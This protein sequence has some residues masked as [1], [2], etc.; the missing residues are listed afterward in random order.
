[1]SS[2]GFIMRVLPFAATFAVAIFITSFFI[3]ITG[4]AF[5]SHHRSGFYKMKRLKLENERL[6]NENLRL[7]NEM[8]SKQWNSPHTK[9]AFDR[10]WPGRVAEIESPDAPPAPPQPPRARRFNK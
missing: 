7:K 5:R 9:D 1:M 8:E 4:P 10:E 2:K 3:N 6:K